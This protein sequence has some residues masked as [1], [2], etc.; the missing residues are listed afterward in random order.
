MDDLSSGVKEIFIVSVAMRTDYG[1][2]QTLSNFGRTAEQGGPARGWSRP[3]G[4]SER[5]TPP[6]P[7]AILEGLNRLTNMKLSA[8]IA[9]LISALFT[10]AQTTYTD[11]FSTAHN[12]LSDG[13]AGTIWDGVYLGADAFAQP[14][15]TGVT[16]GKILSATAS[17]G[18]LS[19]TS[20]QTDWEDKADDGFF[21]Y[22]IVTGDFD[23][24]VEVVGPIDSRA[25]NFPGLMVR[26][27]GPQGAP[28]PDGKENYFIWGRFDEYSIANMLKNEVA[29]AKR[30]RG[31]GTFPNTNYW[32]RI[33]RVGN[34]YNVSEKASAADAWNQ[35]SS[36]TRTNFTEQ[37]Q[38]GIEHADYDGGRVLGAS[39]KNFSLTVSNAGPF[40]A[41]PSPATD[42]KVVDHVGLAGHDFDIS[43]TPGKGSDGSLIAA[44]T[45]EPVL[46]AAPANGVAY[47]GNFAPY[48]SDTFTPQLDRL[49]AA[50]NFILYS[51]SSNQV[52]AK[53]M[54]AGP[55]HF[56]VFS[57]SGSGRAITYS[58]T[59]VR[60]DAAASSWVAPS[61]TR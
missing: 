41:E 32:L 3:N 51:G 60:F 39:W 44:W 46:T 42:L 18:V 21:L 17:N 54:A 14:M 35:V 9:L 30:D 6:W 12:Y 45:G 24:S 38:V 48:A 56:A 8:A 50:G 1:E 59:P 43:W 22:K 11:N 10:Q 23:M 52:A 49:P 61:K 55:T 40:A 29:G 36:L 19:V 25:H 5:L 7:G 20:L 13:V 33:Q 53:L 26:A 4:F 15:G 37:L 16:P 58:H 28:A 2:R 57:Y 47:L 34:T 31:I 27:F